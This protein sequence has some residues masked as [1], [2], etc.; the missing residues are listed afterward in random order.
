MAQDFGNSHVG[1]IRHQSDATRAAL[2]ARPF[3]AALQQRFEAMAAES[4]AEQAR[5]ERA[6]TLDF[7]TFRRFYVAPERM[8]V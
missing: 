5:I 4:L 1:F 7:E 6:D 8:A 2:L 3:P